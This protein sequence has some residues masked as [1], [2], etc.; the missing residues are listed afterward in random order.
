MHDEARVDRV[1]TR[2]LGIERGHDVVDDGHRRRT[3]AARDDPGARR[4]R[5]DVDGPRA[6]ERR[7]EPA[8]PLRVVRLDDHVE[9]VLP[10][11]DRFSLDVDTLS[12]NVRTAQAIQE[13]NARFPVRCGASLGIMLVTDDEERHPDLPSQMMRVPAHRCQPP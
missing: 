1:L 7:H 5:I 10:G 4:R 8:H 6:R 3:S 12:S 11:Y 9:R 13:R 2:V